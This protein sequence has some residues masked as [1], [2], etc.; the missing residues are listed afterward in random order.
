MTRTEPL[1]EDGSP[2]IAKL[3]MEDKMAQ[4]KKL[5]VGNVAWTCQHQ[6]FIQCFKK[7]LYCI[8]SIL[9]EYF[10][11]KVEE[12]GVYVTEVKA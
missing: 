7:S 3:K 1:N 12:N 4:I 11:E 6:I 10:C 2:H 8:Y 5:G 9:L